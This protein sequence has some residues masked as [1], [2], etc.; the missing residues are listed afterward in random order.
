MVLAAPKTL[1]VA[2]TQPLHQ[3]AAETAMVRLHRNQLH[4]LQV[5][6]QHVGGGT[7]YSDTA[8]PTA[9]I[10]GN[11]GWRKRFFGSTT[12]DVNYYG[13]NLVIWQQ[14]RF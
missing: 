8:I 7:F 9:P 6:I 12:A 1:T 2:I 4:L 10:T 3:M 13:F 5:I 11:K 14:K